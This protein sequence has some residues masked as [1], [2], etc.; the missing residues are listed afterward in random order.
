MVSLINKARRLESLVRPS[1]PGY[2]IFFVTNRCNFRCEF[3]FYYDEIEKGKKADELSLDEIRRIAP[4]IGPLMQLSLTGGEPFLR[5]DFAEVTSVLL[6]H[7]HAVRVTIPTNASLT[8]RIVAYLENLLPRYPDTFF[9]I[10]FSIEGIGE[11]HDTLR[12]M[13]GS[14]KKIQESY[15]A[16]SPL[17]DRFKNFSLESNSVFSADSENTLIDTIRHL[18]EEFNFDNISVTYARGKIKNPELQKVTQQRYREVNEFIEGLD[19]NKKKGII[20]PLVRG[21]VEVSRDILMRTEFDDEFVTPCV[22]GKKLIVISETGDIQPCE[23][24]GKSVGNLRDYDYHLPSLLADTKS[25]DLLNWIEDTK[26]KCTFECAIAANVVWS[27]S[28]YPKILASSLRNIGK[29]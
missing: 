29:S 10:S 16:I 23:I 20:I 22:A 26:C 4:S 19:K 17:R 14:Y 15:A 7:T 5:K 6:D 28:L 11:K 13:A 21:V 18:S 1:Q 27:P 2:V 9:R 12:S 24:L 3:C 25:Q 8:D